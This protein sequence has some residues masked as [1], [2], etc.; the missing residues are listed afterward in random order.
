MIPTNCECT[1]YRMTG[2][3]DNKEYVLVKENVR[4]LIVPASNEII[5]LFSDLPMGGLYSFLFSN[6]I[7]TVKPQDKI[8]ISSPGTSALELSS[9]LIVS[10]VSRQTDLMGMRLVE[11]I[12]VK[13]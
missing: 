3:E 9:E 2:D 1:V 13:K 8:V 5:A 4:C 11:G 6:T 7:D 10:G 12:A